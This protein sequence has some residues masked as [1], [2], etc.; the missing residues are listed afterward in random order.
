MFCKNCGKEIADDAKFCP[1]CGASLV[2]TLAVPDN[3][4]TSGQVVDYSGKY[5]TEENKSQILNAL[6]EAHVVLA[7]AYDLFS[8][9]DEVWETADRKIKRIGLNSFG[10]VIMLIAGVFLFLPGI[11]FMLGGLALSMNIL[12]VPHE[13]P[14]VIIGT[15]LLMAAVGA[16]ALSLAIL[17]GRIQKKATAKIIDL[18]NQAND[19]LKNNYEKIYFLDEEYWNPAAVEYLG[20]ILASGRAR[21]WREATDMC[22]TYLHRMRMENNQQVQLDYLKEIEYNTIAA[23][24]AASVAAA[25]SWMN[26]FF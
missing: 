17:P 26:F 16:V 13:D 2:S 8:Q 1:S 18:R 4:Q 23:A 22:D 10:K 12:D 9:A 14:L 21:T 11:F 24:Q 7:K 15:G 19:V 25:A 6:D 3:D 5:L 20:K